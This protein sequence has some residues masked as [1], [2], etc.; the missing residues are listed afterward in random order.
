VT[1]STSRL[2]LAL[3]GVLGLAFA[4]PAHAAPVPAD[5]VAAATAAG[6]AAFAGRRDPVR[7]AEALGFY[8]KA[9]QLR[10]GQP[11]LELRLARAE[12]FHAL[13]ADEP[14]V[15]RRAW[16]L[17]ARAGERALRAI[18][19]GWARAI[20]AGEPPAA[21]AKH[22]EKDGAEA[23]YWLALGSMRAAQA[24]GYAAV[25]AVKDA[26]LGM[27]DRVVALDERIDA[28]G[29]HRALGGWRA[30][31][32]IAA[33]GGATRAR[34]HFDR[35]RELAPNELLGRVLEAETYAVLVQDAKRFDRLLD[36]VKRLELSRLPERAPENALAKRRGEA[37]RAKRARLF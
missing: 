7:L 26:T 2:V 30:A 25:L 20:D 13:A 15:A 9:Q 33:G 28:A 29:P 3:A 21:A 36:E 17:A 22:V 16:E 27:M 35:A 1:R 23:L 8:R 6:D 11:D 34:A 32:P 31:L 37:L 14:E 5:P 12:G 10:P 4:A 19:P 24:T 18:A